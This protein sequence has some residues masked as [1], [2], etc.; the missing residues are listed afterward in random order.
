M[1]TEQSASYMWG[2][3]VNYEQEGTPSLKLEFKTNY[4]PLDDQGQPLQE[5]VRCYSCPFDLV[6][7]KVRQG[8]TLRLKVCAR[9]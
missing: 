9:P 7:Y 6:D 4:R 1:C 5:E 8:R 3:E 2:V